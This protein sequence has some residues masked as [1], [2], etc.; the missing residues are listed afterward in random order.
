MGLYGRRGHLLPWLQRPRSGSR[1]A[2]AGQ[3]AFRDELGD[4]RVRRRYVGQHFV[5]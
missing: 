2:R 4:V 1:A 5:V 3:A